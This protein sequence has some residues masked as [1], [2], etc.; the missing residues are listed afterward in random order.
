MTSSRKIGRRVD[1]LIIV[2]LP[3]E[4]DA[5]LCLP[6]LNAGLNFIRLAT[7]T[8]DDIRLPAVLENTSGFVYYV[9][10]T[11]ITGA[12]IPDFDAVSKAVSRIK[13]HTDLPVAVGFGVKSADHARAVARGADMQKTTVGEI[14]TEEVEAVDEGRL[15]K[16]LVT[17]GTEG[18]AVNQPIAILLE[19]GEDESALEKVVEKSTAAPAAEE[20]AQE[21]PAP[22]PFCQMT[23]PRRSRPRSSTSWRAATRW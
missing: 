12:A 8:T 17:E 3:P 19:E 13:R 18:V 1:G 2:D 11:G 9:S 22:R 14:M 21:P 15:G 7:P 5:E 10:V 23:S 6:A 20:K 4:E 16:I